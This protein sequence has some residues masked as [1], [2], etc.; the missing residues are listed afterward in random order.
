MQP[1]DR[2]RLKCSDCGRRWAKVLS[3]EGKDGHYQP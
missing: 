3:K 1:E 2:T